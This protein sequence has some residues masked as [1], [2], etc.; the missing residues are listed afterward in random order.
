MAVAAALAGCSSNY[1]KDAT[2]WEAVHARGAKSDALS[3][4][5]AAGFDKCPNLLEDAVLHATEGR[6]GY[7][8]VGW[9]PTETDSRTAT[10]NIFFTQNGDPVQA[11]VTAGLDAS[12]KCFAR[13]TSNR[14][15]RTTCD[16]LLR[17]AEW[18]RD[19]KLFAKATN[20]SSV[21]KKDGGNIVVSLTGIGASKCL[22][23]A[24]ETAY[25]LGPSPDAPQVEH[26]P[27]QQNDEGLSP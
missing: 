12:G 21:Y 26:F 1:F 3:S 13:W 16:R 25:W 6:N 5:R 22:V 18:L 17:R 11:D 20:E 19:Y 4:I 9:S 14:V 23:M 2:D 8:V 15:W 27:Y 10:V 7:S 24:G